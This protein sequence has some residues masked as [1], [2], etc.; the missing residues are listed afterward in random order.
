MGAE[1]KTKE[2]YGEGL[3]P[4]VWMPGKVIDYYSRI[5]GFLE[6]ENLILSLREEKGL[7]ILTA[8]DP[9][10][11]FVHEFWIDP[12]K[13]YHLV[14]FRSR[15][16]NGEL[17][18]K[19]EWKQ[20]KNLWYVERCHYHDKSNDNAQFYDDEEVELIFEKFEPM[21]TIPQEVFSFHALGLP[22]GAY[23]HPM[24]SQDPDDERTRYEPDPKFD[25]AKVE[26]VVGK[27]PKV[28]P[29]SR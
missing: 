8:R 11:R 14:R 26:A 24:D 20:T 4:V 17:E 23:I 16:K 10:N 1:V 3:Q 7:K 28:K 18:V 27:L 9:L 13:A 12:A 2:N 5:R 6:G 25:R 29:S 19:R 22:K 21:E 15:H